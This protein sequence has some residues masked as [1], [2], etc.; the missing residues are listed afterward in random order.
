MTR[1]SPDRGL[2]WDQSM[3]F[4]ITSSVCISKFSDSRY[5]CFTPQI[6][7]LHARQL[8]SRGAR[9]MPTFACLHDPKD[10]LPTFA[11]PLVGATVII[12][13][14]DDGQG[15]RVNI[16]DVTGIIR[17]TLFVKIIDV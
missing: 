6:A 14:P 8:P 10:G 13:R 12:I 17:S 11:A 16:I 1:V 4:K 5:I 3:E 9:L 15:Q 7:L 2:L